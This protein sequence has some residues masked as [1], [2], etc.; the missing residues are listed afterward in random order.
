M[1]KWMSVLAL[2][3]FIAVAGCKNMGKNNDDMSSSEPKK[4]ST[5]ACAH[6]PGVQTANADGGCPICTGKK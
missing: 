3:L 2:G 5:D 1:S 6:C 4:M